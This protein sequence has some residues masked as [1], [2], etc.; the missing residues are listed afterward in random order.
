MATTTC[1]FWLRRRRRSRM[2]SDGVKHRVGGQAASHRRLHS[3]R[4]VTETAKK[5][6][7]RSD[8]DV[9][10]SLPRMK[11]VQ[12]PRTKRTMCARRMLT[13]RTT[14]MTSS[15][16][17]DLRQGTSSC[18]WISTCRASQDR[19]TLIQGRRDAQP[20]GENPRR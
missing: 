8:P 6:S 11:R 7:A 3:E 15:I 12:L 13:T 19:V 2:R 18:I 5:Q 10:A 20:S 16:Q 1:V 9:R 17:L 14:S 4:D